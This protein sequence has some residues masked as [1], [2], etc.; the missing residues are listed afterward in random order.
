M[1]PHLTITKFVESL[2]RLIQ[3]N[4][5]FQLLIIHEIYYSIDHLTHY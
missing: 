5:T 3:L 4:N 2:S 1:F